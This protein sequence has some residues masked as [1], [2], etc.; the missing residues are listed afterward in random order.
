MP[1]EEHT[2]ER[3]AALTMVGPPEV[4][5]H[6]DSRASVEDSM[7]VDSTGAAVFMAAD[8]GESVHFYIRKLRYGE[9]DHAHY[10]FETRD[11][12][13]KAA[14]WD[15]GWASLYSAEHWAGSIER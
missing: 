10:K 5:P 9:Q 15:V 12:S 6:V 1:R 14:Q 13:W 2:L 3:S 4:F 7:E 8:T 11:S